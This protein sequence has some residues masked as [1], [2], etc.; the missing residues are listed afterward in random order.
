MRIE[1]MHELYETMSLNKREEKKE[2][3]TE[4]KMILTIPRTWLIP[5]CWITC[6][7]QIRLVEGMSAQKQKRHAKMRTRG[8]ATSIPYLA[9]ARRKI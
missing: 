1:K 2:Y 5:S 8:D 6:A 3:E 7:G 4:E 9:N